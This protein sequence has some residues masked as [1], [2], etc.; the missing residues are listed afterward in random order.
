MTTEEEILKGALS[1]IEQISDAEFQQKAWVEKKIHSYAFFEETMHQLFDDYE[2]SDILNNYEN[3][4]ISNE[5]HEILKKFYNTLNQYSDEK[6]SWIQN[7]DPTEI[8]ADP[9]WHEIQE[10]A[11]EVLKAF[12]Y[13]K[14][15][16]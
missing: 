1:V 13:Q 2:L 12:N 10:M 6:M 4:R 5:Q 14:P 7:V 3:Y 16:K 8:L 11:K 9:R 15:P